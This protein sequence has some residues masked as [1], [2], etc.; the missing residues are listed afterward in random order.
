[1]SIDTESYRK[2][3]FKVLMELDPSNNKP[4]KNI[5]VEL[6][7]EKSTDSINENQNLYLSS[8]IHK[9]RKKKDNEFLI[10]VDT[11]IVQNEMRLEKKFVL[12]DENITSKEKNLSQL[13]NQVIENRKTLTG[14]NA[15]SIIRE[16]RFDKSKENTL[17]DKS[18]SSKRHSIDVGK[19]K[20]ETGNKGNYKYTT[21][22]QEEL[23]VNMILQEI[24]NWLEL[25]E[26]RQAGYTSLPTLAPKGVIVALKNH[27]KIC[28]LPNKGKNNAQNYGMNNTE[29][30]YLDAQILDVSVITDSDHKV[31]IVGIKTEYLKTTL[32]TANT[33]R[34]G[35]QQTIYLYD[36][37]S[38]ED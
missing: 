37:A 33:R 34:K 23:Q 35:Y 4:D 12:K 20:I 28:A 29:Q 22:I 27:G 5:K 38:E 32:S 18:S 19:R 30:Y 11:N 24:L 1:M 14:P 26:N 3:P 15:I 10:E 17:V 13:N 16:H 25:I 9:R 7:Q 21:F 2:N 6:P 36:R 8:E 31:A